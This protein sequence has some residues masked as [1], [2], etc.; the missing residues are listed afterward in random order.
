MITPKSAYFSYT[1]HF[2]YHF[3]GVCFGGPYSVLPDSHYLSLYVSF[4]VA[5]IIL[6]YE[7]VIT[8]HFKCIS[9][10]RALLGSLFYSKI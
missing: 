8:Y 3:V 7:I 4:H 2:T 9:S 10:R 6:C 1:C 5:S